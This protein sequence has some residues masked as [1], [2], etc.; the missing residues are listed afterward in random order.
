MT[1]LAGAVRPEWARPARRWS[2]VIVDHSLV[3]A[4]ESRDQPEHELKV[5]QVT[6]TPPATP[7]G[8]SEPQGACVWAPVDRSTMMPLSRISSEV[9]T[10][11][12]NASA[13]I[14]DG[15]GPVVV[16][17]ATGSLPDTS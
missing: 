11:D 8:R 4:P 16:H 15:W 10:E 3:H 7:I 14:R 2:E 13:R 9:E 5:S 1:A 12:G 6:R 17:W